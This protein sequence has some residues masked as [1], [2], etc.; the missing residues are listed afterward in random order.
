MKT[1][2]G[3]E[4]DLGVDDRVRLI[5][6]AKRVGISWLPDS[7]DLFVSYN[8]KTDRGSCEG[9]WDHWVDLAIQILQSPLTEIVRLDAYQAV[10]SLKSRG[11]YDSADRYLTKEEILTVFPEV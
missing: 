10:G 6:S 2:A 8:P 7:G 4:D 1:R 11:L 3:M 5:D 9:P